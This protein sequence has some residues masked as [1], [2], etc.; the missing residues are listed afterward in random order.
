M[1]KNRLKEFTVAIADDDSLMRRVVTEALL[2]LGFGSVHAAQNGEQLIELMQ[3]RKIDFV[4]C[5][6][7]M[8]GMDGVEFTRRVRAAR[9]SVDPLVPI[10]MLTGNAEAHQVLE[11]RDAGVT[12]YLVKPFTVDDL[13]KRIGEIIERPREFVFSPVFKGPSRRRKADRPPL[14][15]AE[16][17]TR[18]IKPVKGSLHGRA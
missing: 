15:T 12:E 18:D 11:A 6:W 10:I 5:D 2:K 9:V 13:C 3:D 16:R 14:G 4:I 17:R 7:R 8:D 1:A